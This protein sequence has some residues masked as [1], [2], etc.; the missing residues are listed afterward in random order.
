MK[1]FIN[2][3]LLFI[4][5]VLLISFYASSSMNGFLKKNN[6][7]L[8][9]N[10]TDNLVLENYNKEYKNIEKDIVKNSIYSFLKYD[11]KYTK[12]D[13]LDK[14]DLE[15]EKEQKELTE[16]DRNDLFVK[17]SEFQDTFEIQGDSTY[18]NMKSFLNSYTI[19]LIISA[20]VLGIYIAINLKNYKYLLN[21]FLAL[22]ISLLSYEA[23]LYIFIRT[24]NRLENTI[25][26][27]YLYYALKTLL[28]TF[29]RNNYIII[30]MS[31]LLLG[32]Y[33]FFTIKDFKKRNTL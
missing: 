26:N 11:E 12:K 33:L 8:F 28:K 29:N 22:I 2:S 24:T 1:K 23:I 13:I 20:F 16:S 15:L 18:K 30:V 7:D 32:S 25:I 6:I 14:I 17:Y 31:V 3:C 5:V 4:I 27:R 21:S 10:E 19:I 9:F